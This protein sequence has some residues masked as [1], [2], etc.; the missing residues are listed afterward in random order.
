[1]TNNQVVAVETTFENLATEMD[2]CGRPG[3]AH[4]VR[5]LGEKATS[6]KDAAYR[7]RNRL[8]AYLARLFPAGT[9]RTDIP[10]WEPEWQGCVYID[11]PEGQMSWH[12]H[13]SDA[14]LFA[15][16]PPYGGE[17]DGHTTEEKYKRLWRLP[18]HA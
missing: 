2:Q 14:H 10:G 11:T 15:W 13:D 8:V 7:E 16:L 12:Y 18:N 5:E 1:M 3:W 9:K 4:R 17:Y 6:A